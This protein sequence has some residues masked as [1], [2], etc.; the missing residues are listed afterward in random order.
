MSRDSL[1]DL[2]AL[3]RRAA[4]EAPAARVDDTILAAARRTRTARRARWRIVMAMAACV[5]AALPVVH[6]LW[7]YAARRGAAPAASAYDDESIRA[8]LLS[9]EA[10]PPQSRVTHYLVNDCLQCLSREL[11]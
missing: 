2:V 11:P 5:L 3:Y 8:F 4:H 9:P 10:L 1:D 6:V 7:P